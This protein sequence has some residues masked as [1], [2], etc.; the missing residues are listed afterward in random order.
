[1]ASVAQMADAF[2][3]RARA[4]EKP[5]LS[6]KLDH[7]E[8]F[9]N[10]LAREGITVARECLEQIADPRLRE[11]VTTLFLTT[12]VGVAGGVVVGNALFGAPGAQVGAVIGGVVG[13]AVGVV[14]LTIWIAERGD[15]IVVR[16]Q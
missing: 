7:A 13:L 4:G 2:V 15:R 5:T 12:A 16:A 14:A 8:T 9:L 3:A 11:I 6:V 1:M 10:Y